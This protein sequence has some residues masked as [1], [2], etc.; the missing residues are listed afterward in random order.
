VGDPQTKFALLYSLVVACGFVLKV[1]LL[2]G[3]WSF[4][5][6]AWLGPLGIFL[7]RFVA[8]VT[9]PLWQVTS[10]FNAILSF[11]LYLRSRRQILAD[12]LGVNRPERQIER[13]YGLY[14]T[15]RTTLWLY[16]IA[17]TLY[18]AVTTAIERDWPPIIIV[19]FPWTS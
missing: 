10:A 5:Q 18:I 6:L 9:L 3:A 4:V 8:P 13:E 12:S 19:L 16:P 11:M 7:T 17:C 2:F 15:V 1:C 14:Q